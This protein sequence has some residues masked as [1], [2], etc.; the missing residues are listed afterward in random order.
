MKCIL[1]DTLL[2]NTINFKRKTFL[3]TY[4]LKILNPLHLWP[5]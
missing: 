2:V 4:R 1:K 3:K 5:T